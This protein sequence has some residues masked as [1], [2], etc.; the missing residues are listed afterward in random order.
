MNSIA[1]SNY[2]HL[3]VRSLEVLQLRLR[4]SAG[5][6]GADGRPDSTNGHALA[7]P[8]ILPHWNALRR[9]LI[10]GGQVVKRFRV[11]APN[12]E[13]VL[14]AFEEE[15][16]PQR[17]YDPLSPNGDT[18]TKNRLHETIKALNGHRLARIIRFRGDGTGEG[19]CWELTDGWQ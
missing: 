17:V 16:W 19:V 5:K 12:Q 14:T 3:K 15:G 2:T 9:E 7:A 1:K 13:A 8:K 10:V 6:N 4:N 18:D 11:P